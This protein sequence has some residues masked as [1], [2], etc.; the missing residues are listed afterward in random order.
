MHMLD[1]DHEHSNPEANAAIAEVIWKA[2]NVE[3]TTVGLDVGSSTSHL[4]FSRV[5]LQRL[6]E[7]LSSR[8]VVV[9]RELLYQSDILLTPY[10]FDNTI[11]AAKLKT[12]IGEAY[13]AAG[14]KREDI[15]SGA[16]ILTGEALKRKNARA[17]ADLFAEESGKFVCASAGHNMEAIMA[18]HGSGAV[19]LSRKEKKLFLNVD[20]GG[21]TTKLALVKDGRVLANAAFAVGGRLISLDDEGKIVRLEGPA[22][23]VAKAIGLNLRQGRK[24]EPEARDKIVSTMVDVLVSY[25]NLKPMPGIAQELAVTP[26]LPDE[27]TPEAITFSGG[28]SEYIYGREKRE[29]ND[30]GKLLAEGVVKALAQKRIQLQVFDPGQGIRATVIGASQFS[31][32][33]SGNTVMVSNEAAL[34]LRN[35]PV[36]A[37]NVRLGEIVDPSDIAHRI[38]HAVER[39]DI[40][41]GE[42]DV[43]IAFRW[44]GD[45]LHSRLYAFAQGVA[46]GLA[47]TIAS[48]R[49]LILMMEGDIG[50]T[51]GEIFRRELHIGNDIISIDD[52][53]LKDFDFV[54]I[55]EMIKPTNVVPLIIKSLLFSQPGG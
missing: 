1:Y 27:L 3:L 39:F 41:Q 19:A 14:L 17:I 47:P 35:I 50:K 38:Q 36:L 49:P 24:L 9:G 40:T 18:A 29:L 4:I 34:P 21:G 2:D 28:V 16:I 52:V 22:Q 53:Q 5:H 11:D 25:V 54:D 43:A 37:L 45:P 32:Q 20:I 46:E 26:L 42:T 30:L 51:L 44:D 31:V 13:G 12:F 33:V 15:D 8:F 55:G 7:A 23:Q 6:A 10:N 48:R